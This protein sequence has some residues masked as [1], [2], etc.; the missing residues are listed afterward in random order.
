MTPAGTRPGTRLPRGSADCPVRESRPAP[1]HVGIDDAA[2]SLSRIGRARSDR[3]DPGRRQRVQRGGADLVAG[4]AQSGQHVAP[5]PGRLV[6]AVVQGHPCDPD[7][8]PRIRRPRA[9]PG[10]SS[11]AGGGHDDCQPG[12]RG[13]QPLLQRGRAAPAPGRTGGISCLTVSSGRIGRSEIRHAL[14]ARTL[15]VG[16]RAPPCAKSSPG[17]RATHRPAQL[18][19][20][21]RRFPHASVGPPGAARAGRP[22]SSTA[23]STWHW[24]FGGDPTHRASCGRHGYYGTTPREH[25]NMQSKQINQTSVL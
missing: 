17:E 25:E 5:E 18:P 10:S 6:V 23:T 21:L 12:V 13:P 3:I 9:E 14:W 1:T 19:R 15:P 8:L 11:P 24:V 20:R 16:G 22:R 2:S 7:P 4:A